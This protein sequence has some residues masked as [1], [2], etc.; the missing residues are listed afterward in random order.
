MKKLNTLVIKKTLD[1]NKIKDEIK[2]NYCKDNNILLFV[3]KYSDDISLK[4]IELK[5]II[6]NY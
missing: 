1:Y 3:I 5:K 4:L 2:E 6:D